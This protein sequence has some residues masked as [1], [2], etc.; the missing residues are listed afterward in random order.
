MF[1]YLVSLT[2]R[3]FQ[4]GALF[5][6]KDFEL[7]PFGFSRTSDSSS[8]SSHPDKVSLVGPPEASSVV[9]E[10]GVNLPKTMV[11]GHLAT[12]SELDM[13]QP[14]TSKSEVGRFLTENP[15]LRL[16][17][18][19]FEPIVPIVEKTRKHPRR[20]EA[21]DKGVVARFPAD[22]FVYFDPGLMLKQ[23]DQLLFLED[24][25]CLTK[26]GAT[27]VVN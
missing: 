2:W 16:S 3:D 19:V 13:E 5:E 14:T 20:D 12:L 17:Y 8:N 10:V 1:S 22:V 15:T 21:S 24:E 27:E 9:D 11:V 25:T 7:A 4:M 6:A 18:Q 23:V 26:V